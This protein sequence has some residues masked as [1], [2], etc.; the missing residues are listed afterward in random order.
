MKKL[1]IVSIMIVLVAMSAFAV[2]APTAKWKNSLHSSVR[3]CE[4][5]DLVATGIGQGDVEKQSAI[6]GTAKGVSSSGKKFSYTDKCINNRVLQE[7]SCLENNSW[8]GKFKHVRGKFVQWY[9][10]TC[11]V[12]CNPAD[13]AHPAAWCS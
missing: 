7:A 8:W 9:D 1:I 13:G 3:S 2:V 5:S 12:Q 6:G 11:P 4:D 10:V